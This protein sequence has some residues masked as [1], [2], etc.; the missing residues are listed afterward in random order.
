MAHGSGMAL[1]PLAQRGEDGGEV[2]AGGGECVLIPRR[3]VAVSPAFDDPGLLKLAQPQCQGLS[4]GAG[5]DL[6]V[7]EPLDAESQFP[8]NEHAPALADDLERVGDGADT[9]S[10]EVS[11]FAF[12]THPARVTVASESGIRTNSV[13]GDRALCKPSGNKEQQKSCPR[14]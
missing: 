4:R 3:V 11:R 5:V 6:D 1:A 8:E 2:P 12:L 14:S 9:G 13:A 10:P 7:I